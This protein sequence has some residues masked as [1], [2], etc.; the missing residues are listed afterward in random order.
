MKKKDR[1]PD[2]LILEETLG[3]SKSKIIIEIGEPPLLYYTEEMSLLE[4]Y[5]ILTYL[6]NVVGAKINE[7]YQS[8][9]TEDQESH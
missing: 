5:G 7:G 3:E 9:F 6:I 2:S 1:L 8:E 4:L